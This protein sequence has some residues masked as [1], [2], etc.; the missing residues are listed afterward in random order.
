MWTAEKKGF[1]AWLQLEK[2]LSDHSVEAY[3]RDIEKLTQFIA[4]QHNVFGYRANRTVRTAGISEMDR[5]TWY[6]RQF[7]IPYYF[8]HPFFF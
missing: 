8:R 3:L 6:D 5:G 2:S 1:K 7:A 4:F